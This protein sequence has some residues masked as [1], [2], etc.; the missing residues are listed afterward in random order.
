MVALLHRFD[1]EAAQETLSKCSAVIATDYF[2]S[3]L[4]SAAEFMESA[5][6]F[7]FETYCRIHQKIG[8]DTLASKLHMSEPDAEKWLIEL[9]RSA[10]LDA[11]IDSAGRQVIMSVAP[12][13]IYQQVLDKTRDLTSRTRTLA[14]N[15]EGETGSRSR[16]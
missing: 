4:T 5:R 9:M 15:V 13:S 16:Y 1:F 10:Q 14:E 3:S 6:R 12:P 2:L 8:L 11:K 7:L